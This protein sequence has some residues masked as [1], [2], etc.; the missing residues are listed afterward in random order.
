V[1]VI[2]C[3]SNGKVWLIDE[4]DVANVKEHEDALR[5]FV[6][7]RGDHPVIV[8]CSRLAFLDVRALVMMRRVHQLG[9]ERGTVVLWRGFDDFQLRLMALI[10]FDNCLHLD[11]GSSDD[12][13]IAETDARACASDGWPQRSS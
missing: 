8:N 12:L 2:G 13:A 5:D 6:V 10:G 9:E 11:H 3:R 7:A 4:I 1:T